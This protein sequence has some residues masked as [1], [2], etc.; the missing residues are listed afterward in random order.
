[1]TQLLI[2][3]AEDEPEL[4]GL[5][6]L[7]GSVEITYARDEMA[8]REGLQRADVFVVTDFRSGMIERC[9]PDQPSIRWVHATSAGVD[10]LMFPALINSDIPLTNARG[11]FNRGIAEYVLGAILMF[12]KDTLGNLHNQRLRRWQHRETHLIHRKRALIVG[13]GSIGSTVAELLSAAGLD[14]L[15]TARSERE[16][17]GFK[18]VHPQERLPDLLPE[19]DYVIITA[20]LTPETKG[21]F[22]AEAFAAM[23]HS[24][25]LINVGRGPIVRTED[26]LDALKAGALAGAALDVFEE[27]PLPE[28]HPLWDH[29]KVMISAHMAG[30]FIGWRHALGEQFV[31]NFLRWQ[32]GEPLFNTVPKVSP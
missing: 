27:E 7:P 20:P 8:L 22:N 6:G 1:M 32:A 28:D 17:S 2:L 3:T 25:H 4:P 12:A 31:D 16:V 13:A 21:L 10:A 18:A 26:L 5:D 24:A 9:W 14:V 23:K 30:D 11:V 19:A 29:P 15:G